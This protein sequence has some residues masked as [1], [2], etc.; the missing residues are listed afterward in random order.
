MAEVVQNQDVGGAE[1]DSYGQLMYHVR[2]M[3]Q[4]FHRRL[5]AGNSFSFELHHLD[6]LELPARLSGKVFD[7]I[8]VCCP[9]AKA[10]HVFAERELTAKVSNITD[11]CHLGIGK[12]LQMASCLLRSQTH[13]KHA[14]LITLFLNAVVEM[15][16]LQPR[17]GAETK[18][19]LARLSKFLK[20]HAAM[21]SPNSPEMVHI[22]GA[23][24]L[25]QDGEKYFKKCVSRRWGHYSLARLMLALTL[26]PP[27]YM[28]LE[29]FAKM[30]LLSGV[31]MK[32]QNT[33]V[34]PWPLK[35]QKK[36]P[37]PEA[38]REFDLLDMSEHNGFERYVEWTTK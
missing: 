15:Q 25:V 20:L 32:A 12:T 14:T 37:S 18:Q 22:M 13:N 19:D 4:T 16:S 30:M 35:L 33:V 26:A 38:K 7:R 17:T 24:S 10:S 6:A 3:F 34:A 27:R 23:M 29:E 8:E 9:Q 21:G 1:R 11:G 28:E 5:S 31:S 2:N 36:A